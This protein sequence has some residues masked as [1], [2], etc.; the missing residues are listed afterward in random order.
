VRERLPLPAA[1][2]TPLPAGLL[3]V[4]DTPSPRQKSAPSN[5]RKDLPEELLA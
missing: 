4:S 2:R 1:K 5:I 3:P